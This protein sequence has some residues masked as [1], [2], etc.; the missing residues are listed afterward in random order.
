[1]DRRRTF[2]IFI[3]LTIISIILLTINALP[4]VRVYKN[5]VIKIIYPV[6]NIIDYPVE[7]AGSIYSQSKMFL[8]LYDNN[9]KL[10][11]EVKRLNEKYLDIEYVK[12][13]NQRLADLL[14]FKD[15]NIGTLVPVEVLV[16]NAD[17]YCLEFIRT[18]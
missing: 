10:L 5:I 2:H 17:T 18:A 3:S 9:I 7:K 16:K 15:S 14:E 11:E 8:N 6:T 13:E 1:M 4:I 12:K